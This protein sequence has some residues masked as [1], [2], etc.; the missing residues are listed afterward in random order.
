[1]PSQ[2]VTPK[3]ALDASIQA[4]KYLQGVNHNPSQALSIIEPF[5]ECDQ[6]IGASA[7]Q[8]LR[9]RSIV[10]AVVADCYR[11]MGSV[12]IAA[13]WY[14]TASRHW[15][16]GGFPEYYANMVITHGLADHYETALDCMKTT[17]ADWHARPFWVRFYFN[18][19]ALWW[20]YPAEW[21]QRLR[22]RTFIR[23]LE[24]LVRQRSETN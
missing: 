9:V 23:R 24:A 8:T 15:K 18:V 20:L 6:F 4:S 13:D 19:R 11:E 5:A 22:H 3:Q 21:S 2:T 16:V 7:E 17:R 12:E 14:R 1:V 10:C